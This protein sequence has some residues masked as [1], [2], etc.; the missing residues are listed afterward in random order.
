[1]QK[2]EE[3]EYMINSRAYNAIFSVDMIK[4]RIMIIHFQGNPKTIV[5]SSY[6]PT[7]V[8][9]EH[10]TE[11]FY[12]DLT[13]F[14]RHIPKHNILIIGGHFNAHLGKE[15]GYK[16]SLHRTTNSNSNMLHNFL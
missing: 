7:N 13:Y 4:S 6:I 16:Y 9:D 8:S 15:Y 10:D 1:M 5:I 12:T 3:L 2:L 14:I 11:R